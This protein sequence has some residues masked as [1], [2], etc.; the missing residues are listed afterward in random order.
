MNSKV[1]IIGAGIAGLCISYYL[2]RKNVPHIIIERGEIANTWINERWNNF[3]LVNPN[4]AIKIPEFGF[5]TRYFP[6]K[7][8]H[9]FLNKIQTDQY[10]L[11]YTFQ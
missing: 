9:G 6:S 2:S 10:L 8:A 7:N 11:C 5:G 4:W 1:V 3:H